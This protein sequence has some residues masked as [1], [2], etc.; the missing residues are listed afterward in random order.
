MKNKQYR[1]G[2]GFYVGS[3]SADVA[4]LNKWK[5]LEENESVY[6]TADN[7]LV[8]SDTTVA[9]ALLL[10]DKPS[11]TAYNLD[12]IWAEQ[13]VAKP[14]ASLEDRVI[15]LES[16]VAELVEKSNNGVKER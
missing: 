1:D 12:G 9:K 4:N 8:V 2:E 6:V 14:S 16:Q 7:E 13:P 5:V 10:D 15:A 11:D 3:H